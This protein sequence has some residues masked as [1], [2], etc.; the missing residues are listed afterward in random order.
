MIR[1]LLG[2]ICGVILG[3]L[4]AALICLFIGKLQLNVHFLT[5][6]SI[7]GGSIGFILGFIF[8]RIPTKAVSYLIDNFL[9]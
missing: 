6:M 2:A 1:R 8:Y 7:L 5:R 3:I 4:T 9:T